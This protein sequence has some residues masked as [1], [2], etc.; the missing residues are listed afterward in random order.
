M[1]GSRTQGGQWTVAGE[2]LWVVAT[3]AKCA[4]GY[5]QLG[6]AGFIDWRE[7]ARVDRRQA[8]AAQVEVDRTPVVRVDERHL[9]ELAALVHVRNTGRSQLDEFGG[10]RVRP[11]RFTHGVEQARDGVDYARVVEGGVDQRVHPLLEVFVRRGP[12]GRVARLTRGLL[13][14]CVQAFAAGR[15]RADDCL[16]EQRLERPVTQRCGYTQSAQRRLPLPWHLGEHADAGAHVFAAL[17]VMRRQ[18]GER[19]RETGAADLLAP[20]ELRDADRKFGRISAHLG[21]RSETG[22]AV[23]GGV[24]DTL[25]HHHARGLLEPDRGGMPGVAQNRKELVNCVGQVR[26]PLLR[27][28]RGFVQVLEAERK[29]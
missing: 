14:I 10:Q 9:P 12:P 26:A 17:G 5:Q 18:G 6:G 28:A 29:V 1:S 8:E 7:S 2:Q 20:M 27:E 4:R 19:G 13:G 21:E 11:A 3:Q 22:V 24:F 16:P 15:P 25:G 23:E